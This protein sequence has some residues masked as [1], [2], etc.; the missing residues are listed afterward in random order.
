MGKRM[1]DDSVPAT[2]L[3]A[4]AVENDPSPLSSLAGVSGERAHLEDDYRL[5]NM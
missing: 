1:T 4:E 3:D 2:S 5:L